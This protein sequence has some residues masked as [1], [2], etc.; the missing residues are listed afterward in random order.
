MVLYIALYEYSTRCDMQTLKVRV[1]PCEESVDILTIY[2][3]LVWYLSIFNCALSLALLCF[4]TGASTHFCTPV[5]MVFFSHPTNSGCP[6]KHTLAVGRCSSSNM[7][8]VPS[9]HCLRCCFRPCLFCRKLR[10]IRLRL[11]FPTF[12]VTLTRCTR[13]VY[14]YVLHEY[15]LFCQPTLVLRTK[16]S[17]SE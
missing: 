10:C 1:N 17:E 14:S 13:T 12:S 3:I 6:Q 2:H 16:Q 9:H 7:D 5:E 15:L 11:R 4:G 8:P